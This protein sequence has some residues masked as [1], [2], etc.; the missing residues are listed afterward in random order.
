[1][2]IQGERTAPRNLVSQIIS[3][4][5]KGIYDALNKGIQLATGELIGFL[6]SHINMFH[7]NIKNRPNR[8]KMCMIFV[9]KNYLFLH[10]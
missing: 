8:N 3:E 5:D 2:T 10:N 9:Q 4:P 6:N 7:P 1:M